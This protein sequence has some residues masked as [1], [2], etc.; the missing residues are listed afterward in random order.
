MV[1]GD[2]WWVQTGLNRRF[3]VAQ[4]ALRGL[5]PGP[6]L[7]YALHFCCQEVK[8]QDLLAY[9]LLEGGCLL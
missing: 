1:R 5:A 9:C 2:P 7:C 6:D 4:P 8:L 3:L